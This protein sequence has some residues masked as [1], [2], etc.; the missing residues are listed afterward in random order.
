MHHGIPT[1][2]FCDSQQRG[3]TINSELIDNQHCWLLIRGRLT[4]N[5]EQ[6]GSTIYS[7]RQL[8]INIVE[9][10]SRGDQQCW[11]LIHPWSTVDCWSLIHPWSTVDCW[12]LI[13]PWS[14]VDC[15]LSIPQD[16]QSTMLIINHLTVHHWLLIASLL[17]VDHWLPH[18]WLSTLSLLTVDHWSAPDQQLTVDH[19]STPDWWSTVDCW[20]LIHPW[21][22]V[23]CWSLIC[24]WSTVNCWLS[25]HPWSTV[26]CWLSIPPSMF[27][28]STLS[29]QKLVSILVCLASQRTFPLGKS[30]KIGRKPHMFNAEGMQGTS[31]MVKYIAG[32][33]SPC[34]AHSCLDVAIKVTRCKYCT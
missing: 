34:D 17:T 12:S 28:W 31:R 8:T 15:W 24:P 6:R 14:T 10:W 1:M 5:S 23:D 27:R 16:Q 4:I 9:C 18:C 29:E 13:H 32:C 7:K 25:I 22:T 3:S 21:S 20:L 26:D 33:G 30:N 11:S 19:W 2:H